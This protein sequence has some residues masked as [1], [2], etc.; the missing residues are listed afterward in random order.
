MIKNI[1]WDVDGTLLNFKDSEKHALSGCLT[2]E[3]IK[4]TDEIISLYSKINKSFWERLETGELTRDEVLV[5][6]F[7][8]FFERIGKD[9][10][11]KKFEKAYQVALANV[12]FY[13]DDSLELVKRL[14]EDRFRQYIVTN[15]VASTQ[16]KKLRDSKFYYIM[17]GVFISDD[18]GHPK[19]G[20]GFFEKVFEGIPE[21]SKEET[22]IV[23]D[24][25]TSDIK[26]GNNAGISCCWYN[27]YGEK[28]DKDVNIDYEIKNLWELLNILNKSR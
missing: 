17:D 7:V 16:H 13:Y 5:G 18:I 14:K 8:D 22:I 12:F 9:V 25:L 19:P 28:A 23:G 24:S 21:F 27:P 1:L 10:N 4:P 20:I 11:I 6:R 3:G 26:G 15:G 2:R